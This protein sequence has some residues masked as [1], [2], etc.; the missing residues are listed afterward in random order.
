VFPDKKASPMSGQ[1]K[2]FAQAL[3]YTCDIPLS[4]LRTPCIKGDII[5]VRIDEA[6]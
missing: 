3:G 5:V 1:K 6:D 4:Q 2:T